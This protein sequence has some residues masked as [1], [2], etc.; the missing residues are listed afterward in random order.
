MGVKLQHSFCWLATDV[1]VILVVVVVVVVLVESV[2]IELISVS[3][4]REVVVVS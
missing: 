2:E 4:G 3:E 1:V